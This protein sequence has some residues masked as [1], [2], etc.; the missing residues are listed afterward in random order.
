VFATLLGP[1]PRPPL[2]ADAAPEALLDACLALQAEHGLEPLT[3]GGWSVRPRDPAWSWRATAERSERIVKAVVDGPR[4]SRRPVTAVR[5]ELVA[6][7]DA[8]CRWI[9]VREPAAIS[10]ADGDAAER[11]RFADQHH[12]LT[13]DLG[14]DVHLSLAIIGGNADA[15]GIETIL[16][17]SYASLALDL[18]D[19]PDNWRLAVAAP[20]Q[21]GIVCGAV[22][23]RAGSDDGPE[24]LLW[25]AHYAASTGGRGMD[26]VGLATSGS[27]RK[28]TWDTAATKL[29]RL[30]EA[31]RLA[32]APPEERRGAIDPRA[33]DIRSAA[34][35]R[36][37]PGSGTAPRRDPGVRRRS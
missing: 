7:L 29:R 6:L 33:I 1:L 32:V 13:S 20:T 37:V 17:G 27:M 11:A 36:A 19:G 16:A 8:G 28:L 31:A 25:A 26:R 3:D 22:S 5:T 30:G 4:T 23:G 2:A 35:G 14:T 21:V 15:A 18:I 10:L 24:I 12:E 34:L 9:E